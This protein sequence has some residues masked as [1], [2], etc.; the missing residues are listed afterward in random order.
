MK[1]CG[2]NWN[3]AT[4]TYR[5]KLIESQLSLVASIAE[6]QTASGIRMLDLIQEG[7]LGL[8]KSVR[9]FAEAPPGGFPTFAAS[10]TEDALTKAYPKA[11]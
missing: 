9:S 4:R 3:R 5:E 6:K 1:T 2:N 7:N 10:C 11:K 8:M